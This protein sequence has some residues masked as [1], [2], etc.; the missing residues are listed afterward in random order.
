[1]VAGPEGPQNRDRIHDT[2]GPRWFAEDRPIRR[3]HADASMFVGGS[4]RA[5]AA[6]AAPAGDGRRR[7]ALRLP[8]RPVGPPAAHQHLPG[9]DHVRPGRRRAAGASTRSAASTAGCSGV[10]PDG[11][12]YA[13]RP[14]RTCSSGCTSPRSTASCSPISSTAPSR[15]TRTVATHYVADTARVAD[16]L[17]VPDPPRTEAQLAERIE[18]LP[19]RVTRHRRRPRGRH[20]SC[21]SPRRCRCWPARPTACWHRPRWRCCRAWARV[22]LRLPYLPPVEATGVRLSGRVLVGGIRWAMTANQP[23][24]TAV[25][26]VSSDA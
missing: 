1:M 7:R 25:E 2:P 21:C 12:P 23:E 14:T 18:R 20:A 15:S 24:I 6:V 10:A 4:A 26:Q 17:G 19:P 8:R 13:R 9:R 11:R 5:A 22:P 3:V 16:A